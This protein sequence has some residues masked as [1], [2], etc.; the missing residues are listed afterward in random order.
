[1]RTCTL[2]QHAGFQAIL[3]TEHNLKSGD[4][5]KALTGNDALQWPQGCSIRRQR[6]ALPTASIAIVMDEECHQPAPMGI[7]R[8]WDACVLGHPARLHATVGSTLSFLSVRGVSRPTSHRR[9]GYPSTHGPA[10]SAAPAPIFH[11]GL[12]GPRSIRDQPYPG[13]QMPFFGP[14]GGGAGPP[15][16]LCSQVPV[17]MHS[18]LPSTL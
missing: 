10:K 1:M 2:L 4:V 15:T 5:A 9:S 3:R 17:R 18:M 14:F 11:R 13:G 16:R 7:P 6:C 12:Q 8:I